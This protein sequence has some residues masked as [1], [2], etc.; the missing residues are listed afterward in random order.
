[1]P[2]IDA[3]LH[4][5]RAKPGGCAQPN[6]ENRKID[7]NMIEIHLPWKKCTPVV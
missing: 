2:I 4:A 7:F 3:L 1:M 5:L 6:P